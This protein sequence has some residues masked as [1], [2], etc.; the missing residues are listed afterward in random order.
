MGKVIAIVNQKGGVGK[1]TTSH[2]FGLGLV[3][4]GKRVLFIDLDQQVSLSF[5]L[6]APE[7]DITVYEVL[8]KRVKIQEALIKFNGYDLLPASAQLVQADVVI[9]EV[10]KE[11]RLR[12]ILEPIRNDYDYIVIDCPPNLNIL[13][14]LALAAADD[15]I[16]PAQ[17]EVLAVKGIQAFNETYQTVKRY[18]NRPLRIA[19]ILLCR[20]NTRTNLSR[21]LSELV[22][23]V[24]A[25]IGTTV[26]NT[27]IRDAVKVR[28]A[29]TLQRNLFEYAP[30][31]TAAEDYMAL[32][33][34][35]LNG[36]K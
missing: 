24:A 13:T 6:G 11:Y 21:E 16:I 19:G 32:V 31:S 3:A 26:F 33:R 7:V 29:Q 10:G 36:G 2:A 9:T 17:A 27:T 23:D 20:H 30:T 4:A 34:E 12:E 1:T 25:T 14:V 22:E 18:V 15:V 28:E 8:T 35:Y 5:I